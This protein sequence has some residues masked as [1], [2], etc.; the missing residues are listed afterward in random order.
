MKIVSIKNKWLEKGD[1]VIVTEFLFSYIVYIKC[2]ESFSFIQLRK[3]P[4][5]MHQSLEYLVSNQFSSESNQFRV[6]TEIC[7]CVKLRQ[8]LTAHKHKREF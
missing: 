7:L 6:L 1:T 8:I 2:R 3:V 5:D 4:W